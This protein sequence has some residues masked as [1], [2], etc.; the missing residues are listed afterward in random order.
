MS[1]NQPTRPVE[2]VDV[3]SHLGNM[4]IVNY[5]RGLVE[6]EAVERSF[7]ITR[8][9]CSSTRAIFYEM[10]SGNAE[11]YD[12]VESSQLL[13]MYIYV[14]PLRLDAS[15]KE[16][17]TY[18][19]LPRVAGIKSRPFFHKVPADNRAYV[20]IC[21]RA[22]Q[23]K[24][25]YLLH[26]WT[27]DDVVEAARLADRVEELPIILAHVVPAD[28]SRYA[29]ALKDHEN[30][31]LDPCTSL[32]EYDRL[33]YLVDLVGPER[34]VLGTDSTL[35]NPAWILGAFES[36]RLSSEEKRL[37]YRDNALGIFGDRL[38]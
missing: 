12:A 18:A 35:L 36:A 6:F 8:A 15:L 37:I 19:D 2:I 10:T 29:D 28:W 4:P 16:L 17:D 1:K 25:P 27:P 3:H 32:Q 31:F 21:S 24:L 23:L 30:I 22:A 11:M 13:Y 38:R 20:E 5:T 33:R 34:M 9:I 14:D 7:G 26:A